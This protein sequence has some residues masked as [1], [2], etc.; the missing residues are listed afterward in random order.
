M[1][2]RMDKGEDRGLWRRWRA[3]TVN[4]AAEAVPAPDA[5]TLAA[6]AEGRLGETAAEEVEAWLALH[7]EVIEDVLAAGRSGSVSTPEHPSVAA[8]ADAMALVPER[9]PKVVPFRRPARPREP[10]RRVAL[11]RFA[12]AASLLVVSLLGFALGT[13]AYTSLNGDQQSALSQ[14]LFDPPSGIFSG[15]GEEASS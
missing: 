6:Y 2:E 9:D 12:V 13:D 14:D 1:T 8:L 7:P 10:T 4:A 3:A 5:L 15:L 11:A